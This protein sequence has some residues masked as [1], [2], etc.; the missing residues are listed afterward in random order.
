MAK[1]AI[2]PFILLA[3]A[4]ALPSLRAQP[5]VAVRIE[6]TVKGAQYWVDGYPHIDAAQFNW[7]QGSRHTLEIRRPVQL[8]EWEDRRLTF[9]G[10]HD[11]LDLLPSKNGL[12]QQITADP[13]L[14]KIT[15]QFSEQYKVIFRLN[16]E[17]IPLPDSEC[18]VRPPLPDG[19]PAPPIRQHEAGFVSSAACGCMMA[20]TFFWATS[21]TW[22]TLSAVAYPGYVFKNWEYPGFPQS[23]ASA[24][25]LVNRPVEIK[26]WFVQA[27]RLT[28]TSEPAGL[29]VLVNRTVS[30]TRTERCY[31]GAL[32]PYPEPSNP[33]FPNG[34]PNPDS[35]FPRC[36]IIPLCDGEFDFAPGSQVL[37]SAP[38]V[39]RDAYS[40]LWVFDRWS[41]GGG[42]NTMLEIGEEYRAYTM[43]AR[44]VRGANVGFATEPG[45]LKL[46]IDGVEKSK[47]L[48]YA[49]GVG[50][51]HSVEAPLEQTDANGRTY[52]FLGWSNEGA[53]RQ[54]VTVPDSAA[55]QGLWLTARYEMLGRLTVKSTPV[56]VDVQIGDTDCRTPCTVHH[57]AGTE[58]VLSAADEAELNSE[59]RV[60]FLGW[61]GGEPG[62]ALQYRFS[63]KAEVAVAGYVVEHKLSLQADPPEGASFEI[64]PAAS[65]DGWF[66]KDSDVWIKVVPETGFEFRRWD[67]DLSGTYDTG[68]VT[69][70][71]PRWVVAR[72]TKVPA[73]RE[74]AVRNAAAKTPADAVAPGS[75]ISIFGANLAAQ[76]VAGPANPYAQTIEGITVQV[77]DRILPLV[78]VSPEQ[79]NAQL[80]SD[81]PEGEHTL[82]VRT[83]G[84]Q[85]LEARF[86]V[87]RNAPGLYL[88]PDMD[89][90]LALAHR[91][92]GE[93]VTPDKPAR[94]NERLILW[95]TGLGPTK[96][97][98]LDG[99]ATPYEP[100]YPLVD[101][102]ELILGGEV[103]PALFAG[104][105]PGQTG[106][107]SIQLQVPADLIKGETLEIHVRINGVESNRVLLPVRP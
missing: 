68:Q 58:I 43:T 82:R 96:P 20:S 99:F 53:A 67:G 14:T 71:S 106:I 39:Q 23:G 103:R 101:P 29:Q 31:Q 55:D 44:F 11:D 5:L 61:T 81:L 74:G 45:G 10:W 17:P 36:S 77:L 72:M 50:T 105:T 73:L 51:T 48:Y 78:F 92:N 65:P 2:V 16:N 40:N 87:R 6:A 52:R 1:R 21:G 12:V 90:P 24:R 60:R 86:V 30:R 3:A 94:P 13:K 107:Q 89:A 64:T 69:M 83:P 75:I 57:P 35:A 28:V 85:P 34:V 93:R 54:E 91:E 27:R 97:Q 42:Q 22:L 79:I 49:W 37:L 33:V 76:L 80:P 32:P 7:P 62:M 104:A 15:V 56:P 98:V 19:T 95:G 25:L 100:V 9:Q 84:Q 41:A 26:A 18:N 63:D 70:T 46:K 38:P 102:V 66:M 47:E 59:T 88:L 4:A 8:N